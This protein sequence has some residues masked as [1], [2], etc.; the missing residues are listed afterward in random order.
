MDVN[1]YALAMLRA[2]SCCP[3]LLYHPLQALTLYLVWDSESET[4]EEDV[5][6]EQLFR[7]V[8][9]VDSDS[10]DD[11]ADKKKK[12]KSKKGKKRKASSS[13]GE[14]G[15]KVGGRGGQI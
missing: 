13:S 10:D 12:S 14:A 2:P 5:V 9:D 3:H 7:A 6:M 8:D 1:R 11:K 15:S 4:T